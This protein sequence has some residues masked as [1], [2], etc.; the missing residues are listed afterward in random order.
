MFGRGKEQEKLEE[1][2]KELSDENERLK[3][4]LRLMAPEGDANASMTMRTTTSDRRDSMPQSIAGLDTAYLVVDQD[5]RLRGLN[6]RM[7]A[8]LD[9]DK[10]V[11][12]AKPPVAT[13]DRL[14]WAKDVL[15]TLLLEAKAAGAGVP[16]EFDARCPEDQAKGAARERGGARYYHFK[17]IW[18]GN[19]GTLTVEDVTK[20]VI[21]RK[22]FERLVAPAIV[23]EVL[24][25]GADVL[26]AQSRSMTV[27]FADLRGFTYFCDHAPPDAVSR[28]VNEFMASAITAIEGHAATLDK[29]VGD[30]V[31]ALFGAPVTRG[32]HAYQAVRFALDLQHA[33]VAVRNRW[34]ES[35]L[36]RRDLLEKAPQLLELGVGI[37]T[38]DMVVGLFG[39]ERSSQY[40]V[41]GHEVNVSARLCGKAE[42][43]EVLC[44]MRTV[45]EIAELYKS[46][47]QRMDMVLKFK[48]K[49]EIEAKGVTEPIPVATLVYGKRV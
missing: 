43:S 11:A 22:T 17:A 10:S 45:N 24:D 38:G 13:L 47:P 31:M 8:F 46:E 14:D 12:A 41:M 15:T 34:V 49:G 42:A 28:V 2:L 23:S 35:G 20:L 33:H 44:G 1:Q 3:R 26:S 16:V 19:A 18:S 36:L 4:K 7:C 6:S 27:L 37:N 48:R 29:F 39:D 32:D 25:S 40:T 21:T 30:Q 5:L 9:C